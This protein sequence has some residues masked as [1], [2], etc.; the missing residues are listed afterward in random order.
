[1]S[2]TVMAC[3]TSALFSMFR[4]RGSG[5]LCGGAHVIKVTIEDAGPAL[6][7]N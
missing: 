5:L 1:M 4:I 6:R 3:A 2:F 7:T